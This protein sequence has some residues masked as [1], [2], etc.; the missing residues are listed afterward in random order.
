MYLEES[1]K[2]IYKMPQFTF[3]DIVEKYVKMNIANPFREGNGRST[4]IWLD[5][6]LKKKLR[7]LLT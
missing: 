6:I 2:N 1:L 4:R 5:L 3:D 7:G